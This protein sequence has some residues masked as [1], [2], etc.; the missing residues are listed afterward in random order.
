MMW[1]PVSVIMP[2]PSQLSTTNS[3]SD[4]STST[5]F[6]GKQRLMRVHAIHLKQITSLP[7]PSCWVSSQILQTCK[8]TFD[9]WPFF[10]IV[11]TLDGIYSLTCVGLHHTIHD[12]CVLLFDMFPSLFVTSIAGLSFISL[13]QGL[14]MTF[15]QLENPSWEIY[16]DSSA[17]NHAQSKCRQGMIELW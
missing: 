11:M 14:H 9:Q 7:P 6:W 13:M 4:H 5:L 8:I 3:L 15:L 17:K 1:H 10:L 2:H 12:G 16:K